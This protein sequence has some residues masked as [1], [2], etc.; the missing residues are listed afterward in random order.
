MSQDQRTWHANEEL[1]TAYMEGR[2]T[3][4]VAASIEQHLVRCAECR[5]VVATLTDPEPLRGVWDRIATE[6]SAP[7]TSLAERVL[8]RLGLTDRDAVLVRSAPTARGAWLLGIL[9]CLVFAILAAAAGGEGATLLFLWTAPLVPVLAVSTAFGQDA[10]PSW[11][12]VVA[13]PFSPLRLVLLRS[14]AVI[15][16][17]L[18][19]SALAGA[20]LPGPAWQAVAW[21]VPSLAGVALTLAL[22]TWWPVARAA[23]G[24]A[25]AWIV[26]SGTVVAQGRRASGGQATIDLLAGGVLPIYV[27]IALAAAVVVALRSDRLS[28]MGGTA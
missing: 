4:T 15:A 11:E 19:L 22:A 16:T 2:G 27:L 18:P 20:L 25:I 3:P 10:D 23:A 7:S 21:L 14:V 6:V 28:Q 12:I 24:V 26:V 5:E 9:L 8:I 17:A 1:L 13:S